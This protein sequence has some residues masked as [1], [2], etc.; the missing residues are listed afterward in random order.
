[1][2][3]KSTVAS[4]TLAISSM[5]MAQGSDEQPSPEASLQMITQ[6]Y[7]VACQKTSWLSR[8]REFTGADKIIQT[9][10]S[11]DQSFWNTKL[12]RMNDHHYSSSKVSDQEFRTLQNKATMP[13]V[14]RDFPTKAGIDTEVAG[15]SFSSQ[16]S[17]VPNIETLK[18]HTTIDPTNR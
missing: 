4:I 3:K 13:A 18:S 15:N 7:A 1:M 12:D 8:L 2:F 10:I 16:K 17:A 5:S 6:Q 11:C 9:E 14:N